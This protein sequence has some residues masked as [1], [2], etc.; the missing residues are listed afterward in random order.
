[1]AGVV[2]T[3][4][5]PETSKSIINSFEAIQVMTAKKI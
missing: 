1:M 4:D 2:R 3:A 5:R